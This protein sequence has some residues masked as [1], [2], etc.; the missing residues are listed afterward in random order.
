[1]VDVIKLYSN[2]KEVEI[3]EP[4]YKKQLVDYNPD[5]FIQVDLPEST[6]PL[7]ETTGKWIPNDPR[8]YEQWH[9]NNTGQQGGTLGADI[10]L[11]SA[12]EIQKG[13]PDVIVAVI[14]G[15][16]DHNHVDIQSNMWSGIGYN[17]VA[18]SATIEPHNHGTHV[19]GTIAAVNNNGIGVS[20]I[21]GGNGGGNGVRLMSCQVFTASSS[22]GFATA[23]VW[24]ADNGAVISQNSWGYT[25]AGYYEQ[26]VLD[27]IDYFNLNAGNDPGSPLSG[28]ITIFAAG[29]SY[30]T[31]QWYPGCYSGVM[32]VA[33]TNNQ[34]QKSW[35]SN[36]D[37]WVE[38]SA[39]GGETN[40]VTERGVLSTINGNGYAFYQGTSMACPHV[41]GVAALVISHAP[42]ELT[43][44]EL[45]EILKETTDNHY[46]QNPSYIGMLGVGRLNAA[47]ALAEAEGLLTGLRNPKDFLALAIASDQIDLSWTRNDSLNPIILAYNTVPTFGIPTTTLV[48]GDQ[49]EGGGFI[50]Y[51]GIDTIYS[52][53]QLE[54]VTNYYYRIWSYN[55][56]GEISTGRGAFA[57]TLCSN[58]ELPFNEDAENQSF[59]LCWSTQWVG[60]GF[61]NV[62][63]ISNTN[64]AGGSSSGEF[65]ARYVSGT[66]TSRL[67]TPPINTTGVAQITLR[68]K[69]YF[70]DYSSGLTISVQTSTDGEE[71][72]NSDWSFSSGSGNIGPQLVEIDINDNLNSPNTLIAFA[73][74]GNH[75][76]FDNW[77][78][79][80]IEIEGMPTGAPLVLTND[81]QSI[82]EHSA[83]LFGEIT[84][85]GDASITAS[86]FVIST[87]PNPQL[88]NASTIVIQ[89][90]PLVN[91]GQ[92]SANVNNL[93]AA[94]TYYFKSFATNSIATSY[95]TQ[96]VFNTLCGIITLPYMQQFNSSALPFCWENN[97]NGGTSGQVWQFGSISGGLTGS[98]SYAYLNSDG[99]GYGNNQN[100][101]LISPPVNIEGYSDITLKFNHYFRQY[102]SASTA[103]VSY[104]F[105]NGNTWTFIQNW[106]QT[107]QNPVLFEQTID[108]T[109]ANNEIIFKWNFTGS[110]AY[111]W[112]IDDIEV[113]GELAGEPPFVITLNAEDITTF[114]AKINAKVNAQ[115][116]NTTVTFKWGISDIEE[117]SVEHTQ[118][119]SGTEDH[120]IS[121]VIENL[122]PGKLYQY[123]ATASNIAGETAGEPLTF[124]TMADKPFLGEFSIVAV[125]SRIATFSGSIISDGGY[126][127]I[128]SGICIGTDENPTS[129]NIFYEIDGQEGSFSTST[130]NLT[131]NTQ[132]YARLYVENELGVSYSNELMFTTQLEVPEVITLETVVYSS[133]K[134][135]LQG[136]FV[137]SWNDPMEDIGFILHTE[138]E[139]EFDT[140]GVQVHSVFDQGIENG[141]EYS[142]FV[143]SLEPE[144]NYYFRA[145]ATNSEGIGY[146]DIIAFVTF[147]LSSGTIDYKAIDVFPN[148]AS[149][150][151]NIWISGCDILTVRLID[152]TGKI[153]IEK[154][155]YSTK[156]ELSIGSISPGIYIL[157]AIFSD[158]NIA[159]YRIVKN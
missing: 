75:Y 41:S 5:G 70:D 97:N 109:A 22:G 2:L 32:A 47:N 137:S 143:E 147:P 99:Y 78:I 105:D 101:D 45:R 93:N 7:S 136:Q 59:P 110:W 36:Y 119:I 10:D 138:S 151:I 127:V 104:S 120:Y 76:Q 56:V 55:E 17:F 129:E 89:T 53:Q 20:G 121:T 115:N 159:Y 94:S 77:Y 71:W 11:I 106:T 44:G 62:W 82:T 69:H 81:P 9:Y 50:L 88:G 152:L 16:I 28:G 64:Y 146:G 132:Y 40:T 131:P 33:A 140:P 42:G 49:I 4:I 58:F 60:E 52:H 37:T 74:T 8:F 51:L 130:N 85:E 48:P 25:S 90:S 15:G 91:Q 145:Y 27:A 29:N 18:N 123:K 21:A 134:A 149:E 39:P 61:K 141:A 125:E 113:N 68:F 153:L 128:N 13:N 73:I 66:A 124:S 1:M 92:Y 35:Y 114:T 38:I 24:A 6:I 57:T 107:T 117:N 100:A 144:T 135:Y 26:A 12:W 79:D 14:D 54:S 112:C 133:E 86:G 111:Y 98:S 63:S 67:I 150:T 116:L 46:D 122:L 95:G 102:Q 31:G 126:P 80:N 30:S 23:P 87:L 158:D 154:E 142:I 155:I 103:T 83:I 139:I 84:D 96:K 43:A 19:A 118:V 65:R 156:G 34:D 108:N 157:R 148:P 3:A 72:T